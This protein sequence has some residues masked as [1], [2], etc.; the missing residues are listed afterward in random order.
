MLEIESEG[1]QRFRRERE[2]SSIYTT[3]GSGIIQTNRPTYRFVVQ[4]V[5]GLYE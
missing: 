3:Q 1:P 5:D 2:N 4:N